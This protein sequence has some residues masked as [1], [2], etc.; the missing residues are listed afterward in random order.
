MSNSTSS[1]DNILSFANETI[2]KSLE[3][4][5]NINL[6]QT[7]ILTTEDKI[8]LCL[9]EHLQKMSKK[10]SWAAPL[11]I[12]VTLIASLLTTDTF[13]P[14]LGLSGENWHSIFIFSSFLVLIWFIKSLYFS[15]KNSTT[16]E[17]VIEDLKRDGV[18]Y[19]PTTKT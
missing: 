13:H 6:K 3:F 10:T 4:Q 2:Q 11:G 19:Q 8:R 5:I 16:T 9:N 17:K 18:T 14:I 12:F 7:C 15:I 1:D